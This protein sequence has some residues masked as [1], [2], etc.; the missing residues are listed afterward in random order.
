[1]KQKRGEKI[2]MENNTDKRIKCEVGEAMKPLVSKLRLCKI[3][4]PVIVSIENFLN[5]TEIFKNDIDFYVNQL[6]TEPVE[7]TKEEP[8][9]EPVIIE[10]VE[11]PEEI[12]TIRGKK[13]NFSEL[14][15]IVRKINTIIEG[16][17]E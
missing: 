6:I 15:K 2:K 9:K 7:E 12:C 1:M 10:K 3:T 4:D 14:E 11:I 13:Y 8:T 16:E 5:T 17:Q